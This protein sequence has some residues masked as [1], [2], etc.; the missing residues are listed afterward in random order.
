MRVL[1]GKTKKEDSRKGSEK[2]VRERGQGKGSPIR[3]S[4]QIQKSSPFR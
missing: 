3:G 4:G 2:G 1:R